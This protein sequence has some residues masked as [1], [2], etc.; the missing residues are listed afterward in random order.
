MFTLSQ[1]LLTI[2]LLCFGACSVAVVTMFAL[3]RS[4]LWRPS[5]SPRRTRS[6]DFGALFLSVIATLTG[7]L[8]LQRGE[9]SHFGVVGVTGAQATLFGWCSVVLGLVVFGL[10]LRGG[11]HR[12]P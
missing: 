1:V 8:T 4:A 3:D 10:F 11:V 9:A 6:R 7:L 12:G 5:G 2:V